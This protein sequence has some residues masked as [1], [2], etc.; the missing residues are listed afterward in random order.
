MSADNGV[1]ILKTGNQY[2]VAL[3]QAIDNLYWN[4]DLH[5]MC[6][7]LQPK[8]IIQMFGDCQHTT[9]ANKAVR[10]AERILKETGFCEYGI[11][12]MNVYMTWEEILQ[13]A[14][15]RQV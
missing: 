2:R 15:T 7:T 13:K 9:D 10:I 14:G 8:S 3:C 11:V 4:E 6:D 5:C 1:Y 12:L